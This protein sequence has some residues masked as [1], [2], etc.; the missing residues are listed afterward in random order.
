MNCGETELPSPP[1]FELGHAHGLGRFRGVFRQDE[2]LKNRA[3]NLFRA[4]GM[5]RAGSSFFA[6][7]GLGFGRSVRARISGKDSGLV[8]AAGI[9]PV[10]QARVN[11]QIE[12]FDAYG[13]KAQAI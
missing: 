3:Q 8:C 6:G 5:R 2:R 9:G 7:S 10:F 12:R 4:N 13:V 1:S 11:A